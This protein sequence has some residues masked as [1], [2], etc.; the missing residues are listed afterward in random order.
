ME[1]LVVDLPVL[2]VRKKMIRSQRLKRSQGHSFQF[3]GSSQNIKLQ[4]ESV[5]SLC[6]LATSNTIYLE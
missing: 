6:S 5:F 2:L 1:T 4:N 3:T